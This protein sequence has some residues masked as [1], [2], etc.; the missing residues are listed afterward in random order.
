MLQRGRLITFTLLDASGKATCTQ[1]VWA[2]WDY[3]V[4]GLLGESSFSYQRIP[5][6][7]HIGGS[8]PGHAHAHIHI[9]E[10]TKRPL[11][12]CK[13]MTVHTRIQRLVCLA[14]L[15]EKHLQLQKKELWIESLGTKQNGIFQSS[16]KPLPLKSTVKGKP[17]GS[18]CCLALSLPRA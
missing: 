10:L 1:P 9:I 4:S 2:Q 12:P 11:S 14:E 18:C 15:L 13:M 8:S 5:R 7:H 17:S 3:D 6:R 16:Y